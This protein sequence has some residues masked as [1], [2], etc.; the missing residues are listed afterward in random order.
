M[1]YKISM[2]PPVQQHLRNLPLSREGK[3]K[4]WIYINVTIANVADAVRND[5]ANRV[6]G[7][8]TFQ[9]QYIFRDRH[10]DG[11]LHL[12]DFRID[13]SAAAYGVLRVVF[14]DFL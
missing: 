5:P 9:M 13:D 11:R 6:S 7:S 14:V 2:D 1:G 4:V 3:I 10:G 12:I 8:E